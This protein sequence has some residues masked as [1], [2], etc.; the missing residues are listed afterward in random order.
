V[1]PP[2]SSWSTPPSARSAAGSACPGGYGSDLHRSGSATGWH[3]VAQ[4][5]YA[6]TGEVIDAID[7]LC[8]GF[9][10]EDQRAES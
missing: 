1:V 4:Q 9:T 6:D 10:P 3:I 2:T 8:S 7:L 5:A